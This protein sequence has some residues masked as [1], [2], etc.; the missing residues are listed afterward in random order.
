MLSRIEL[1]GEINSSMPKYV[2]DKLNLAL[3]FQNK[4]LKDSKILI[5]GLGYK[6]NVDDMRGILAWEFDLP[7]GEA[8]SIRL[9]TAMEW[10]EGKVLR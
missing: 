3:N 10:P 2:V 4:P 8:Q 5:L 1:A 7:G 9:D 6:K